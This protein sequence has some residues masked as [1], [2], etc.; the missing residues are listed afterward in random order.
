MNTFCIV[1][2]LHYLCYRVLYSNK[3]IKEVN[4]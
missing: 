4:L 2:N 1:F 3:K